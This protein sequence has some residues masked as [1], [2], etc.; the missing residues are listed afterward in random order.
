M[1]DPD[2]ALKAQRESRR[3]GEL[4]RAIP[5]SILGLWALNLQTAVD[6]RQGFRRFLP[7]QEITKAY[8]VGNTKSTKTYILP[9]QITTDLLALSYFNSLHETSKRSGKAHQHLSQKECTF[10]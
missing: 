4:S 7:L 8:A 1:N 2:I 9:S 3:F 6:R 5:N 10:H